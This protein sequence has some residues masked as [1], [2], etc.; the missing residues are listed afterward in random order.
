MSADTSTTPRSHWSN[1]S[2]A[3]LSSSYSKIRPIGWSALVAKRRTLWQVTSP[4]SPSRR[5]TTRDSWSWK[6]KLPA[7][8]ATSS[9]PRSRRTPTHKTRQT[10]KKRQGSRRLKK[11][12]SKRPRSHQLSGP[13]WQIRSSA[14]RMDRIF[15]QSM[16]TTYTSCSAPSR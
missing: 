7:R 8:Q 13:R 2:T 3:S 1:R 12:R 14:Q 9:R 11:N 5:A 4:M 16:N 15:G 10:E 6:H